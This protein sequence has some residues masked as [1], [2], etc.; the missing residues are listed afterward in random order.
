[1]PKIIVYSRRFCGY[2]T[3]AK[4]LLESQNYEFEEINLDTDPDLAQRVML[5]AGMRTVPII[6]VGD[7][8][9]GGFRELYSAING[10]D[11]AEL[12]AA[13]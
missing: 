4:S 6:T 2:C 13:G 1:M 8:T 3:A 11:F 7:T 10:G 5:K 12:V 9:V